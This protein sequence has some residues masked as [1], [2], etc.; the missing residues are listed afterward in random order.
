MSLPLRQEALEEGLEECKHKWN[1]MNPKQR[2]L[3]AMYLGSSFGILKLADKPWDGLPRDYQTE[4]YD[5]WLDNQD[6]GV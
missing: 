2:S 4:L 5:L 3:W 6:C 1:F